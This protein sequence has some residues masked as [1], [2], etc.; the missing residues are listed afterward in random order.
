[1]HTLGKRPEHVRERP[2]SEWVFEASLERDGPGVL[3][4][5][6]NG[7]RSTSQLEHRTLVRVRW[8]QVGS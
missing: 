5:P 6:A 2:I 3:P 7:E 8:A 4:D 1:M